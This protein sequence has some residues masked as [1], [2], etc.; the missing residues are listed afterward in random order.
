MSIWKAK[1]EFNK[2]EWNKIQ[3]LPFDNAYLQKKM[4][5]GIAFFYQNNKTEEIVFI[6]RSLVDPNLAYNHGGFQADESS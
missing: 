3:E 4:E 5:N 1:K 6:N 2:G